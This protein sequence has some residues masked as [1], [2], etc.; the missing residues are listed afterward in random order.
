[1][2][3]GHSCR[4]ETGASFSFQNLTRYFAATKQLRVQL[5]VLVPSG[6][7]STTDCWCW[8]QRYSGITNLALI[9]RPFHS[10]A[11]KLHTHTE[12]RQ[13]RECRCWPEGGGVQDLGAELLQR[14]WPAGGSA[15]RLRCALEAAESC[16]L[17]SKIAHDTERDTV[18]EPTLLLH[19]INPYSQISNT[20]S[21]VM[22]IVGEVRT[23]P[24]LFLSVSFQQQKS[25]IYWSMMNIR[26]LLRNCQSFFFSLSS[27][28]S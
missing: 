24:Q 6:G 9:S 26:Q 21:R 2:A 15:K 18:S 13:C 11:L 22:R 23:P 12:L 27:V 14:W 20:K 19:H 1:M 16:D 8:S 5:C 10:P 28:T 17:I 3:R 25:G 7:F 4:C